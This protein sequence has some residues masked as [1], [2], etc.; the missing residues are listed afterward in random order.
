MLPRVHSRRLTD[1]IFPQM[2]DIMVIYGGRNAESIVWD[3]VWTLTPGSV[4]NASKS[5]GSIGWS[6]QSR[7]TV[8]LDPVPHYV[9]CLAV[10]RCHVSINAG[11]RLPSPLRRRRRAAMPTRHW[12]WRRAR[13]G[14]ASSSPRAQTAIVWWRT[15]GMGPRAAPPGRPSQCWCSGAA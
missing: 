7:N 3:D 14:G 11:S 12:W 13:C 15:C 1:E 9:P 10:V 4:G 6:W 2:G 8:S 5:T